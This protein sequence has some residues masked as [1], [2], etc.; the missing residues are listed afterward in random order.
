MG[1][2][3]LQPPPPP[4]ICTEIYFIRAVSS[5]KE[6]VFSKND[7]NLVGLESTS[8]RQNISDSGRPPIMIVVGVSIYIAM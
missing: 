5:E 2:G 8:F 3:G 6:I 7:C 4:A 1:L